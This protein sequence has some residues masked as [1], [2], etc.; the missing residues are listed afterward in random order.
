MFHPDSAYGQQPVPNLDGGEGTSQHIIFG[1]NVNWQESSSEN[2]ENGEIAEKK[3]GSLQRMIYCTAH[4]TY[5]GDALNLTCSAAEGVP[6]ESGEAILDNGQANPLS[7]GIYVA[8]TSGQEKDDQPI[9]MEQGGGGMS[10][11]LF[12][13]S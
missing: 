9:G 11:N 6:N 8:K 2:A 13:S 12:C 4:C 7:N 1:S 3:G 10:P 5:D